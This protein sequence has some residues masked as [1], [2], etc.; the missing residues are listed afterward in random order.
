MEFFIK[1]KKLIMLWKYKIWLYT[2]HGINMETEIQ[3]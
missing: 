3:L 2:I 1:K